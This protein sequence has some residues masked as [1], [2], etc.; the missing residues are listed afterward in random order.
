MKSPRVPRLRYLS[1]LTVAAAAA[2]SAGARAQGLEGAAVQGEPLP[3]WALGPGVIE[4][5]DV[6]R[7][8][9]QLHAA[10]TGRPK[11]R[12]GAQ[13][14]WEV[15]DRRFTAIAHSGQHY[16]FAKWGD[17]RMGIGFGEVVTFDGVWIAGHG[18]SALWTSGLQVVGYR[19]GEQVAE[20]GWFEEIDAQPHWFP[21]S[22]AGVDRVE[23]VARAAYGGGGYYGID[24]LTYTRTSAAGTSERVVVDF[25]DAGW[26]REL[27]GS[28]YAGLTWEAGT[29]DFTQE[30]QVVSPPRVPP[31]YTEESAPETAEDGSADGL[32]TTPTLR[33]MFSG[34]RQSDVGAG[35]VPPD[36]CGSVGTNHFVAT[37]NQHI[38]I[39]DKYDGTRLFSASMQSF[40]GIGSTAGD[41]R[42]AFD[43]HENRWIVLA[44]NFSNK[45]RFAY[46]LTDDPMGSWFKTSFITSTGSDTGAYPDYPTLGVDENGIYS[47]CYMVGNNFRM[48]LFC[49]DKAPLL[50]ATPALGTVTAF[51]QLSWEGALQPAVTW[52]SAPGEYVISRAGLNTQRVRRVNPPLSAPTL[53]ELGFAGTINGNSPPS[54][55]ALGSN[56]PL[57]TLGTRLMN[58]VYR[59][60]SL[61][62]AHCV[63]KGSLAAVNWYEIDAA[64]ATVVQQGTVRDPVRSYFIPSIAVNSQGDVL[65]AFSGSSPSEYAGCWQ[66]GRRASDPPGEMSDE[67]LFKPG[68]GAYNQNGG[69]GTNRWGD[70]SLTCADPVDDS[71]WTIQEHARGNGDWGTRIANFTLG[72]GDALNY[73]AAGV[74]ASGCQALIT[75]SGTPS[76]SAASGFTIDV[77]DLEG[78]KD[79]L[80]FWGSNGKQ[81]N[82]WGNGTSFQ[83]VVPPVIRTGLQTGTGTIGACDGG[84]SLDFNAWMAGHPG[85]APVSGTFVQ[86]QAWYRDPFNTSNQS[87][88]LSDAA[89]FSICP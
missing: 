84:Y 32:G 57:D 48:S 8:R 23:F 71:L 70:Y 67:V 69:A 41:P 29:G 87:T 77:V 88:S 59:N 33:F 9:E 63:N 5:M 62:A 68:G 73:C 53:S 38:S 61:W 50:A 25:E 76:A 15:P 65:L 36:T 40:F 74:S 27:S 46:S 78:Q 1:L 16:A 26:D 54:A 18:E 31:G 3:G 4:S 49:I 11:A 30:T 44:S 22:L 51:R 10:A 64:S 43:P 42:V 19:D 14:T 12:N 7:A 82:S 39:Y 86:V 60:G 79:G 34:P 24:D 81:T 28:K 72:C 47:G 52:G 35:Y 13:G 21:V 37:V 55:P 6:V 45:L 58:A 2:L 56:V 66:V 20:S 75:T 17:T 85:K 83:C 80:I 89:E